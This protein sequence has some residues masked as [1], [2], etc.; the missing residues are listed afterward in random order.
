MRGEVRLFLN[1]LETK[2]PGTLYTVYNTA[3]KIIYNDRI[4]IVKNAVNA[5]RRAQDYVS[6]STHLLINKK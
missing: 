2:R 4:Q 1:D 3:L 6:L 5:G